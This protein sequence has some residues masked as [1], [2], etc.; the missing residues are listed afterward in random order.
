MAA[1]GIAPAARF[2]EVTTRFGDV[3]A[4]DRLS[5]D[6]H[7]GEIVG[8]LGPAAS[9][10]TTALHVLLG[11][12]E[13]ASGRA[14]ALGR[15]AREAR[16]TGHRLAYIPSGFTPWPQLSGAQILDLLGATFGGY[17]P[18]YRDELVARFKFDVTKPGR[19]YSKGARGAMAAIAALMTRAP[20]LVADEPFGGM[21]RAA[22]PTLRGAL[23]E[24]ASRG[25]A[26]LLTSRNL[27]EIEAVCDRVAILRRGSLVEVCRADELRYYSSRATFADEPVAVDGGAELEDVVIHDGM[28]RLQVAGSG[29]PL[30]EAL[31][32][33]EVAA[34]EVQVSSGDGVSRSVPPA[35]P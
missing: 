10:K 35:G 28:V 33:A 22:L 16:T 30:L 34:L 25:Q 3:T 6:V 4:I 15:D 24:A 17:D 31:A 1:T 20:L 7:E 29:D 26:V 13:P 9:G 5:L 2:R 12:I 27:T 23:C 11:L 32:R 18:D 8:L 19:R 21:T 14:E